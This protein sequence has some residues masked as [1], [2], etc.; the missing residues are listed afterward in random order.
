V[1]LEKLP[2]L[3]EKHIERLA[4]TEEKSPEEERLLQRHLLQP[5]RAAIDN[6]HKAKTE[7][8]LFA[9]GN[10]F[11]GDLGDRL[12]V[13]N[14]LEERYQPYLARTL[15]GTMR[16]IEKPASRFAHTV[17]KLRYLIWQVPEKLLEIS[18]QEGRL[19]PIVPADR[20]AQLAQ[21]MAYL[22]EKFRAV[23]EAS[24]SFDSVKQALGEVLADKEYS[25]LF[26]TENPE[27]KNLQLNV[28][29]PLR[30]ALLGMDK[31]PTI[32]DTMAI[33][34]RHET[35]RRLELGKEAAEKVASRI[36]PPL[37]SE[38]AV[39]GNEPL[40]PA[41]EAAADIESERTQ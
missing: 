15:R 5:M 38:L 16:P 29:K 19:F 37:E 20:A 12:P 10:Y 41:N 6:I 21:A 14:V 32:T 39:K 18:L 36:T 33:L 35:L 8:L 23:D 34:G 22:I 30:W 40:L 2:Y 26:E 27:T 13:L 9:P 28:W 25:K 1:S 24:W 17:W 3:Q 31:G 4:N 7:G 11:T